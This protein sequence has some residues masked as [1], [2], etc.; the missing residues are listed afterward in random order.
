MYS[1]YSQVHKDS[2][3]LCMTCVVQVHKD[4]V[5]SSLK[6]CM[7]DVCIV[8]VHKDSVCISLKR[9]TIYVCV[10]CIVQVHKDSVYDICVCSMYCAGS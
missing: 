5:C 2:D 10:Q 9:C 8:Q 7:Y 3:Y 4:S 1:M 6:L